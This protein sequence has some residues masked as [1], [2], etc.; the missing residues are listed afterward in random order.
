LW[1][2]SS[3]VQLSIKNNSEHRQ[4]GE[5][6]NKTY[7]N[8]ALTLTCLLGFGAGVRAQDVSKI[9]TNVPFEFVAGGATLPA[10][11]YAVGGGVSPEAPLGLVLIRSHDKSALLLPI[12]FDGTPAGHGRFDFEHVGDRYFLSKV[13]T[14][15]G[16]YTFGTRR[17]MTRV[18]QMKNSGTLTSPG[19]N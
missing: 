17:A 2:K 8:V 7:L 5:I 12:V 1:N 3:K 19:A 4:L 15:W 10:G 6:M 11:T 9:V 18:A 13:E 14:Q 16:V